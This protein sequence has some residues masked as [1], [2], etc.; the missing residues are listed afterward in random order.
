MIR[1]P[2]RVKVVFLKSDSLAQLVTEGKETA[3]FECIE[4]IP[5]GAK[6]VGVILN[7]RTATLA[8]YFQWAEWPPVYP[9]NVEKINVR[10]AAQERIPV[11]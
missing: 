5:P 2:A 1:W 8:L 9:G 6:L 10:L 4:G 3:G 11:A 7:E